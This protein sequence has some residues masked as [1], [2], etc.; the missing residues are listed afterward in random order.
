MNSYTNMAAG[1]LLAK[2]FVMMS[3]SIA[4]KGIFSSETTEKTGVTFVAD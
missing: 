2:V 3:V 4:S 1:A